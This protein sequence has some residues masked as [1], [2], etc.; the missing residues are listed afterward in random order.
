MDGDVHLVVVLIDDAYHLLIRISSG[1]AHQSAKSPYTKI[2]MHDEIAGLHLLQLFHRQGEFS[3]PR[4]VALETVFM[5]TVEYLMVGEEAD[6]QVVVDESFVQRELSGI[7]KRQRRPGRGGE[8]GGAVGRGFRVR[9][10]FGRKNFV[11]T[12]LLFPAFG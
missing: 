10:F 11:Q 8:T 4:P 1:D 7:F 3:C 9:F 6:A 12:L 5:K 2:D